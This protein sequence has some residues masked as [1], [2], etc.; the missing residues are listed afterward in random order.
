V[1]DLLP[2]LLPLGT[3]S[4]QN[5][6]QLTP[7]TSSRDYLHPDDAGVAVEKLLLEDLLVVVQRGHR[8]SVRHRLLH[9]EHPLDVVPVEHEEQV[10]VADQ[11]PDLHYPAV[12]PVQG[13][14]DLVQLLYLVL[15]YDGCKAPS[16][17]D[18][19]QLFGARDL[20]VWLGDA[21]HPV[22]FHSGGFVEQLGHHP[23]CRR[24]GAVGRVGP[25][26]PH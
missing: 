4:A 15:P 14:H 9:P 11:P 16:V 18:Q 22:H 6:I 25:S 24:V 13:P 21:V 23:E 26:D 10:G 2:E 8:R 3:V 1:L 5:S 17:A 20:A 12:V 19:G 7:N